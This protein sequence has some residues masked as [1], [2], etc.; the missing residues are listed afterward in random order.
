M[1]QPLVFAIAR[2]TM[3]MPIPPPPGLRGLNTDGASAVGDAKRTLFIFLFLP[4]GQT[5]LRRSRR[6]DCICSR[7]LWRSC[8]RLLFYTL[9]LTEFKYFN[10]LGP[11]RS[12]SSDPI[13]I[14]GFFACPH[15]EKS[16]KSECWGP[17]LF[18][19]TYCNLLFSDEDH[20]DAIM[21]VSVLNVSTDSVSTYGILPPIL[22]KWRVRT[23]SKAIICG[24][25]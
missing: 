11:C 18:P 7:L 25:G 19:S 6:I 16:I 8:C 14:L 1:V 20:A 23:G 5:R 24:L 17:R 10:R 9:Q 21:M 22:S 4:L 2:P 3:P 13:P 15:P 12:R